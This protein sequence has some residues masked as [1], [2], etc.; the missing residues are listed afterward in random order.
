MSDSLVGEIIG[1]KYDIITELGK[2]GSSVVYLAKKLNTNERYAIKTLSTD[3]ENAV[4]L[5]HRETDTLKRINH[6]HIVKFIDSGY[7][8]RHR[9]V[10]LVLEYLDGQDI[11]SYFDSG[12]DIKTKLSLFLQILEGISYAHGKNIVHRDI[13]PDNIKVIDIDEEPKVKV[14]D[15]GIA[16]ITTTVLTNTIRSYHTPLFSAPEQINLEGVSRDSDV[17]SLGMTFL[18]LLSTQS[19]RINF[20]DERD[21]TILYES[22]ELALDGYENYQSLIEG[23]KIAT[24]IDREKRP[25]LDV[26]RKVIADFLEI[27]SE[28]KNIV[29][30]VTPGFREKVDKSNNY[31][32]QGLRVKRHIESELKANSGILYIKKHIQKNR[33]QEKDNRLNVEICIEALAKIYQGFIELD[34]PDYIVIYKELISVTPQT[35]EIIVEN[36]V[37]I[38]V[39]PIVEIDSNLRRKSDLTDLIYK[40]WEKEEQVENERE[41]D[42]ALAATFEQ[43]QSVIDIEK[44]IIKE[45]KSTFEYRQKFYDQQRQVVILTLA[46]PISVEDLEKITSPPLPVIISTTKQSSSSRKKSRQFPIGKITD[47]EKSSDGELIEKLHI[48][49][50]DFCLDEIIDSISNTGKIETNLQDEESEIEKRRK[51][52]REIRYG[53]SENPKLCQVIANPSNFKPIEPILIRQ[54]FNQQLDESQKKAVCKALATEEIFLIQGPPGTGKTSVIT[55]IIRQIIKQY[56]NDKILI[57]SQS[58]VAVDNVLT[59]IYGVEDEEIKCIRIGR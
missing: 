21:K 30:R 19:E 47:G 17:Y 24:N 43:W 5:L 35:Q 7:E 12:I 44:E 50:G 41:N 33:K 23:L 20:Q 4:K 49:I 42:R 53:D 25:K 40:I 45:Q 14:L 38:K 22:V 15:F 16:I 8:E 1:G 34:E 37:E 55:E 3:E 36:G 59:R 9:L 58:N 32:G 11:K 10:Y 57:S 56:P 31:Q 29:F 51:A 46:K 2:G 18:Y 26:L 54:F 28:T 39:Y 48:S 52:L 27:L 6:P 13:K